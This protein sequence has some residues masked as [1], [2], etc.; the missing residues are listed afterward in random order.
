MR[1]I[2]KVSNVLV[3]P[4]QV[5]SRANPQVNRQDNLVQ[6]RFAKGEGNN[7]LPMNTDE[8]L[9]LRLVDTKRKLEEALTMLRNLGEIGPGIEFK[10][11]CADEGLEVYCTVTSKDS[12]FQEIRN[13]PGRL[14]HV[15]DEEFHF[16]EHGPSEHGSNERE[17]HLCI[18]FDQLNANWRVFVERF[19]DYNSA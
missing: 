9:L 12:V 13:R 16:D 11:Y 10:Q 8:N 5:N 19:D 14:S 17:K 15:G 2:A 7:D 6:I 3:F 1:R 4:P 18:A